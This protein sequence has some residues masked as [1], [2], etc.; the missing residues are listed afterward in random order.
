MFPCLPVPVLYYLVGISKPYRCIPDPEK[1]SRNQLRID[2][3]IATQQRPITQLY[4]IKQKPPIFTVFS[5]HPKT[6]LLQDTRA[7]QYPTSASLKPHSKTQ[8]VIPRRPSVTSPRVAV[9][10]TVER[11]PSR[12]KGAGRPVERLLEEQERTNEGAC[13]ELEPR[14]AVGQAS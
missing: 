9:W 1:E 14:G 2:D 4:I 5:K 13:I 6:I 7:K 10:K 12:R 11:S 3:V 8:N